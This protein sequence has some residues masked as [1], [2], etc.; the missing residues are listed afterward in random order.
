MRSLKTQIQL[1]TRLQY[2]A[3][4]LL[5]ALLGAFY[6][7]AYRPEH[8]RLS[9][10]KRSID[11]RQREIAERREKTKDL[12]AVAMEVARLRQRLDQ[13]KPLPEHQ[14]LP[15]FVR[16]MDQLSKQAALRNFAI[17]PLPL[18]R[19]PL[20][21]ET[22]VQFKFEGDFMNVY[23]FLRQAEQMPRLTRVR[24]M[25]LRP[26]RN[27]QAGQVQVVLSMNIYSAAQ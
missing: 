8:G 12:P 22:P 4:G 5:L 7:V 1:C 27:A 18:T 21:C 25:S 11:E 19:Q 17:N 16:D 6:L 14:D 26:V 13:Y 15:Q 10:L 2:I 9:A 3:A 20:Y 23:S 24:S